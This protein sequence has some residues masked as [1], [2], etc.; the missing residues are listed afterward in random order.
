M[1]KYIYHI[2]LVTDTVGLSATLL[3]YCQVLYLHGISFTLVDAILFLNMRNVFNRLCQ[4]IQAYLTYRRLTYTLNSVFPTVTQ[5]HFESGEHDSTCLI[6]RD[7]METGKMLP[8]QHVFHE[9]CIFSWLENQSTCPTCRAPINTPVHNPPAQPVMPPPPAAQAN[10]V[11]HARRGLFGWIPR[12]EFRRM[13]F[14]VTPEMILTVQEVA[15]HIPL[16]LIRADL[17]RTGSV[18]LTIENIFEGRLVVPEGR[19]QMPMG[20]PPPPAHHHAPRGNSSSARTS[21][22][23]SDQA[24]QD[25]IEQIEATLLDVPSGFG[26]SPSER[27][28]TLEL[29][30]Q[31]M[32]QRGRLAVLKKLQRK[33]EEEQ[34]QQ[35]RKREDE[36]APSSPST[37]TSAYQEDEN[38][39]SS[40]VSDIS[41]SSQDPA[42]IRRQRAI[43]AAELR[44]RTQRCDDVQ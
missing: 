10:P 25:E 37:Y 13:A 6:C 24:I 27:Q 39:L 23:H 9:V 33:K 28:R 22:V 20:E 34:Q 11:R 1:G 4:K 40:V 18:N 17:E 30:K 14:P 5:Q 26:S 38:P 2:D 7:E 15:P 36:R 16:Q 12:V 29:R 31:A 43:E 32:Q 42:Q 3:H 19:N 21:P 8:C 35:Q 41:F 44:R